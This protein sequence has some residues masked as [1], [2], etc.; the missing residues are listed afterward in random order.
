[1]FYANLEKEKGLDKLGITNK[2]T[3]ELSYKIF[4]KQFLTYAKYKLTIR[5][6]KL[7]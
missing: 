7:Q 3:L 4:K 5:K 2:N 6:E 1:M